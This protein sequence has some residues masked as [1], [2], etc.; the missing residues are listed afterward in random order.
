MK[1]YIR[2]E[3]SKVEVSISLFGYVTQLNLC[4]RK[5]A[6]FYAVATVI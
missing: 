6:V 1:I 4:V 5:I 2:I 3:V